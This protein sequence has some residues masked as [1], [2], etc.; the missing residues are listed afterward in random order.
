MDLVGFNVK[1]VHMSDLISGRENLEN[2]D[3]IVAVGGFSNSDVLGSAKGW[4]GSFIYN[5]KAKNS[6]MRFYSRENTLSLGVCNGC[7]LFLELGLLH[8][9]HKQKPSMAHNDSNKFECIFTSVEIKKNKTVMFENMTGLKLGIW[10][11]HGEGKFNLPL[12]EN[13][14][15]IVGKYGYDDYPANPNGSD[16]NTAIIS[17]DDGRHVAMMP[18]LERSTFPW[19]WPYYPS[20]RNDFISPWVIAFENAKKWLLNNT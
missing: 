7:Q 18:H 3:F 14:Y 9:D 19:N 11:A 8:P 10:S 5:E 12:K 4:A 15:H 13:K 1:D 6:L 2:I 20:N 17:N 16:Y